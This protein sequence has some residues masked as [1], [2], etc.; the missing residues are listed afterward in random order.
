M[1]PI[2]LLAAYIQTRNVFVFGHKAFDISCE[3]FDQKHRRK[4]IA[5]CIDLDKIRWKA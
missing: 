1:L 4:L 5:T 3:Q 2:E